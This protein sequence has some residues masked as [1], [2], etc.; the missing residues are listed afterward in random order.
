MEKKS[1][2][3]IRVL[4]VDDHA[5]VREGLEMILN[6]EEDI[7]VVGGAENGN[8][9][10]KLIR[11][12]DPNVVLMDISMPTLNG[13]DATSRIKKEFYNIDVITLTMHNSEEYIF[14][15]FRAGASGYVL[16]KSPKK[17]LI[18]AIRE[19]Y[20]GNTYISPSIS[21]KV[22]EEYL[23]KVHKVDNI[24][25]LSTRERQVLQ[26]IAEGMSN[27]EIADHLNISMKTVSIHRSHIMQ[28]LDIHGTAQLTRYAIRKGLISVE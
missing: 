13:I 9:A 17:E 25:I 8:E 16:K 12:L 7:E 2:T 24:E 18:A 5:I 20:K 28:K 4:I 1:L 14:Q 11:K 15:V 23:K 10:L 21:C 22:I 19:V 3:S 26:L 27:K 6:Q